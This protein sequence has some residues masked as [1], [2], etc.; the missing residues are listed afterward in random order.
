MDR[1]ARQDFG[2]VLR[3]WTSAES[4]APFCNPSCSKYRSR[5]DRWSCWAW[6]PRRPECL[7]VGGIGRDRVSGSRILGRS[8]D[9]ECRLEVQLADRRRLSRFTLWPHRS[10]DRGGTSLDWDFVHSGRAI[11]RPCLGARGRSWHSESRG[12]SNWW[13]G[14][15]DLLHCWWPTH[16]CVGEPRSTRGSGGR[17]CHCRSICTVRGWGGGRRF[18]SR[19]G[20]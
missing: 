8:T 20:R 11:D 3:G 13:V 18:A 19:V 2:E 17:I 9:L 10:R 5:I 16:F 14:H 1:Q 7:V 6:L 12:V 4:A 15:D